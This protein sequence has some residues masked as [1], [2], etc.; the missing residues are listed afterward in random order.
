MFVKKRITSLCLIIT[1]LFISVIGAFA[2]ATPGAGKPQAQWGTFVS[3]IPN[4]IATTFT[5]DPKTTRTITWQT[6]TSISSGKV[7]IGTTDYPA[8]RTTSGGR[9][10]YKAEL[11]GLTPGTTYNYVCGDN[12]NGYSKLY[13]FTTEASSST[14]F[15]VPRR[16]A[17]KPSS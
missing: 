3:D 10:F 11:T 17:T 4:N 9:A 15:T 7:V 13:S 6:G 8:A 1:L 12:T 5:G 2:A 16:S 14:P